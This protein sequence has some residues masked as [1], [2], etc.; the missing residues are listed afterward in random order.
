MSEYGSDN[1]Q[2]DKRE[3]TDSQGENVVE[4]DG[5]PVEEKKSEPEE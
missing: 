2:T 1:A 5:Q 4:T 3:Q